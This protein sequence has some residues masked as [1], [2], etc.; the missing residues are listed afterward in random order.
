MSWTMNKDPPKIIQTNS[1]C[2]ISTRRIA[3]LQERLFD[4]IVLRCEPDGIE[5]DRGEVGNNKDD[6]SDNKEI[7]S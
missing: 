4:L 5:P 1:V 7:I 3:E 6:P 2:M